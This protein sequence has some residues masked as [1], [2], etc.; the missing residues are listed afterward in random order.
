M[1]SR[2]WA[3]QMADADGAAEVIEVGAA[4]HADVLAGIDQVS[5]GRIGKGTGPAAEARP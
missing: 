2:E 5:G 4:A 1:E 3:E